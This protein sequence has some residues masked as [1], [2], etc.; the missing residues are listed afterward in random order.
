MRKFQKSKIFNK[1]SL[2]VEQNSN[3]EIPF[4]NLLKF[5]NSIKELIVF[6]KKYNYD[7]TKICLIE[8]SMKENEK[9]IHLNFQKLQS[10]E[11]LKYLE[12]NRKKLTNKSKEISEIH[13]FDIHFNF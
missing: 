6:D 12:R 5:N 4:S 11:C 13:L 2:V 3:F 7:E 10:V 1:F 8:E 9:L